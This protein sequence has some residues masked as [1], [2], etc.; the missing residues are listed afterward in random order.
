MDETSNQNEEQVEE[1]DEAWEKSKSKSILRT[2]IISGHITSKMKPKQVWL[3]DAEH[4]RYTDQKGRNGYSN[5][6]NNLR[7]LREAIRRDRDRMADDC[8]AYGHD[9]ALVKSLRPIDKKAPWHRSAAYSLLKEDVKQG[10][11]KQFESPLEFYFSRIEYHEEHPLEVF[12][13]HL[14]QEKDSEQK[15]AMRFERKKK[16]WKYPEIH[17][18]HPRMQQT[19]EDNS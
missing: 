11:D 12:R 8:L 19:D 14:Y 13:K 2:G 3:M 18:N 5:W 17:N 6:S 7:N 9:L 1:V 4:K 15:R 10:V 16:A